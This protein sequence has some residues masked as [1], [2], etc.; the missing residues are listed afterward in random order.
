M[1]ARNHSFCRNTKDAILYF[2]SKDIKIENIVEQTARIIKDTVR[3]SPDYRKNYSDDITI[4]ICNALD[5]DYPDI[6]FIDPKMN[7]YIS[8]LSNLTLDYSLCLKLGVLP[9]SSNIYHLLAEITKEEMA[10]EASLSRQ[11]AV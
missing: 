7:K 10:E 9:N 5:S 3:A 4:L 6:S 8:C 2:H 1:A 11:Q